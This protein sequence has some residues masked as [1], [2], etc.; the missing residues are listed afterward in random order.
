MDFTAANMG[1]AWGSLTGDGKHEVVFDEDGAA[2]TALGLAP[3]SV[4]GYGPSRERVVGGAA[5]IDDMYLLIN[6]TRTDFDRRATEVHELGHTLGLAHS[7]VGF[8][9][10]KPGALS[11]VTVGNVPTMHPYSVGGG[12]QRRT[13][14]ADDAASLSELYPQGTF[15]STLGTLTGTVTRCGSD[16]PVL[17]ANVRAVNVANPAIQLTRMTG[18]DGNDAGRYT[19]NG[20]PPGDYRILVEPLSG[21]GDYSPA[22]RRTRASTPTSRRSTT[23]RPSRTT[24]SRTPI[25]SASEP[26]GVTAAGSETAN[27]KVGG[28]ELA[29]VIDVT[30]SMGP[31]IGAVR[32]AL[33][34]YITAVD[35]LPGTFPDTAVVTFT[36]GAF[37]DTISRDPDELRAVVAAL[38]PV[39]VVTAPSPPTRR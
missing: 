35:A 17:G 39:A 32:G 31:E 38:G 22:W 9:Q 1:T 4:N 37:V 15:T 34:T 12:E 20:V 8:Y 19:I 3:A 13:L 25:P 16:D 33:N 5:V 26:V 21:D 24:A 27:L 11:P 18:F 2:L 29:L 14:E 10:D 6:G 28:V 23:T 30:G 36:D 7:S